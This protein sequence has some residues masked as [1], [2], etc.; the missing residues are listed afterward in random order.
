MKRDNDLPTQRN[1]EEQWLRSR[2]VEWNMKNRN[3][4]EDETSSEPVRWEK[5]SS[6]SAQPF[7]RARFR[8]RV[9]R[10]PGQVLFSR[11]SADDSALRRQQEITFYSKQL[12]K[13]PG[14]VP[15]NCSPKWLPMKI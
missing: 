14:S 11:A 4:A 1:P 13:A 9:Q 2:V 7:C 5:R 12:P 10:L 15:T 8:W 3:R 6:T